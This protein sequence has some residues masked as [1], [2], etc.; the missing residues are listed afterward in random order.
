MGRDNAIPKSFSGRTDPR[1]GI[2][3]NAVLFIGALAL[4]GAFALTYDLGA[5]LL[6]FGALIGFM[7]VNIAALV[8]YYI[9]EGDKRPLDLI[10]P[11]LV[12]LIC[13][14]MWLNL[15]PVAKIAGGAWLALGISYGGWKTKG[16]RRDL[17]RFERPSE[18]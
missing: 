16:F 11:L 13:L 7:G 8:R 15:G 10:V 2:P 18:L 6:N 12:F 17:V 14:Y 4:A 5:Q 1:Q 9:R 3:R